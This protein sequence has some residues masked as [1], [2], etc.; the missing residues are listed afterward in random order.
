MSEDGPR[1]RTHQR[2]VHCSPEEQEAIR[3]CARA[4]GK[5]TTRHVLELVEADD[6]ERHPLVLSEAEQRELHAGVRLV[7]GFVR[8]LLRPRPEYGGLTLIGVVAK[9]AGGRAR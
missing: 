8:E 2:S 6:P 9:L 4:A 7:E 1:R 3:E 5:T